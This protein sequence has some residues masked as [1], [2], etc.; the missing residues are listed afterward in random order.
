M[1]CPTPISDDLLPQVFGY[2]LGELLYLG[3][4]TAVYRAL[5]A[6][7]S[8][9]VV[10]KVLRREY[11]SFNELV[12]FC[13]QYTITKNLAI[14]GIAKP[15]SLESVGRCYA[16]IMEDN[17]EIS[18]EKY[19]QQSG[20]EISEVLTIGLQITDILHGLCQHQ[21]VHKDIKPANILI[22]PE[23]KQVKL[24]DFSIA[25]LLPK[26]TQTLLNP[27][28][29]EGTLAYLA[30]E[31]TGRMNRAID[32]R[33]DF[34]AFGVT[35]YQLLTGRL[36]F[37]SD[38]PLELVHCHIAQ[39][40]IPVH[41]V[42]PDIPV[43]VAKIVAKLMAKN[44]EDRYQSAL[45]LKHDLK[46]CLEQWNQTGT[47]PEFSLGQRDISDR[48]TIPEKLY[49]R[50]AEVETLL[51]AFERVSQGATELMLV[52]GFSGIG[53]TA[54]VNEVH[55]PITRQ[56]GYFIKGKFDQFNRNIP[57]SAF[58]QALRDLM[59]QLLSESDRQLQT[60]KT[61]ILNALGDNG[62]VMIEVIPELERIIGAQPPAPEL[63]GTAAQNRFNLLFQRFIQVFTTPEH[64]LVMFLDDLQWADSASL[65]LMQVL[66]TE[67]SLGYLLLIGA[68]R[69][70]EVFAAHPL[71]LTLDTIQKA[72]EMVNT[73]ALQPL[74]QNSLNQLITD[75]LH[76]AEPLAEPL[77]ELV[78]QKTQGNPFFTTQFLK[79]LHQ[80]KLINFDA[81]AGHWQCDIAQVRD[82]ALTDDVVEFMALQLQKLPEATQEILK[83]AACIG[84]QFDLETLAIVGEQ[85]KTAVA[86]TLWQ[87]LH[88]GLIIPVTQVY[89][90][91]QS[92]DLE[93][94][95]QQNSQTPVNPGY[96]F[97][98]DRIQQAAYS[99][100]AT[101]QKQNIH[102]KMGQTLLGE[103]SPQEREERL[104]AIVNHLNLGS[105]II[106]SPQER[107]TL[108]NLNLAAGRKAKTATAYQAAIAYFE[109]GIQLLPQDS[110][111][112][113]YDL[114]LALHEE[115][116]ESSYL[117]TQYREMERWAMIALKHARTQI[118]T[119]RVQKTRILSSTSEGKLLEGIQL[120]LQVLR[121]LGFEFPEHPTQTEIG[122]AFSVTRSLWNE[123]SLNRLLDLPPMQNPQILA[124][125]EI[126]SILVSPAYKAAPSIM[127]LLIFKQ[128]ELSIQ[129]GNCPVSVFS[130]AD[131]GLI[132]CGIIGDIENG[133]EFGALALK[134]L[135]QLQIPSLQCRSFYI[136]NQYIKHWKSSL[137]ES[138]PKLQETYQRGLET[139]DLDIACL[140]AVDYCY[141]TYLAGQELANLLKTTDTY[142]QAIQQQQQIAPLHFQ[143]I[144]QQM[145]LN[146]L[147][148]AEVPYILTGTIFSQERLLDLQTTNQRGALFRWHLNQTI[149]YY[150]FEQQTRAAQ[151]SAT[152]AQYLD[153]VVATFAIPVYFLFDALIQ[154]A[155]YT[156]AEPEVRPS[157]LQRIQQHQDQLRNWATFAPMNHQHRWELVAAEHYQILGNK[158][159]AIEYYDRAIASAKENGF[160][161]DEA[162]ANELAAKFYLNWGKD[163]VAAGYLQEA[164]YCYA[165]WGAQAKVADL[166]IRYPHLL[167]PIL[168]PPDPSTHRLN[169]L[170]TIAPVNVTVHSHYR[171][172]SSSSINQTLDFTAILRASQAL[173]SSIQLEELLNH[174]TQIILQNSG[175]DRCALILPNPSEEWQVRAIATA[176]HTHLCTEELTNHPLLPIK[177]IQYVKNTQALVVIDNLETDLPVIGDYLRQHQP[178]SVLCLPMLNQGHFTG[179]LL[180]EN[181]ATSGTFTQERVSVLN[182]LCTQAAISLENARLYTLEQQ[183]SDQLKASELRLKAIFEQATDA[184]LLL[185]QDGFIDCNQAALDLF[186][187]T[188]KSQLLN[189]YPSAISPEF[190]P[191]GISSQ[192][193][194]ALILAKS[195]EIGHLRFEWLHQRPNGQHFF[196]EVTLTAIPYDNDT[197]L[198][199]L[200]RDIS[201]RKKLER[202]QQQFID[203]LDATPDFVGL[204]SAQG[205]ILWHNKSFCEFRPDLFNPSNPKHISEC[206]P[207]WTNQII[208]EQGLPIAIQQGSW[209]GEVVLL[210]THNQEVPVSQVIIAHKSESGEVQNFSTI[211]RD[212]SDRKAAEAASK[213]FQEKL[214]FLIQ[215]TPIG[216]IEWNTE[217]Q[218]MSWNPSAE[219]IFG[220]TAEEMLG[221]HANQIVP[222]CD[223]PHV[224]LVM[225]ALLEQEGGFFSLNQNIRKDQTLITCEWINTPLRDTQDNAIGIFSMIQDVSD[226]IAAEA[227]IRQK[228]QAL[229][230]TLQE[231]QNTQLQMVQSEKMASLGNLV[232]GI[233]HEINN[234]IGFL[235]GSITNGK[236]YL[237]DLLEHLNL[238]QTHYPN[239]ATEIQD[240]A[241]NIDLEFLRQDFLKLIN[242]MHGATDRIKSI[243]TSLRTFSR[244]DLEH[245]V[246]ANL[247]EGID[248]TILILKY[249]LKANEHRPAIEVL[250]N[251]GDIPEIQCFPGQINQVFMNIIANAID[252]FDE[253]A[254]KTTYSDLQL[255]PQQITIQT[256]LEGQNTV[257]IRIQDN[258][259]GMNEDVKARIFDHL[260]TTKGVGQGTGL[261][262]AIARQIVEE[263]HGGLLAVESQVGQGSTF[264]IQLPIV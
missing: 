37:N 260:F 230:Q 81:A 201:D 130:Y 181:Q 75:T 199:C 193:K 197:I 76:C 180:L 252:M 3:T 183:K 119:T 79:T 50:E 207:Q 254:Q 23:S 156:S 12:Q 71:M 163:K 217:F 187:Y 175:A 149:L 249:R 231:L 132:L 72:G 57:L 48:F 41:Q 203:I 227:T 190:Q 244:A 191:D 213:A 65:N 228:S 97:L 223:R 178:K 258:G 264:V 6:E 215:K 90:F 133:Y 111:Q 144:S 123:R 10:I 246:S 20:L 247:H 45:G 222:E 171:K 22:H 99:L 103:A 5:K 60:W 105:T 96:R 137:S 100:I 88:E 186:Q 211:M 33:T 174:L 89:R 106:T 250:Q 253:M 25:S 125:M 185:N 257:E 116:T 118:D 40:P 225:Q 235:N 74:S 109:Q 162:L 214:T 172:S 255:N 242:S 200:V 238:Y 243:S 51:N 139:G 166:E 55:K 63:S 11:P 113:H 240:H 134:L 26:E 188:E 84:A 108:A 151:N 4:R 210:D 224:A 2:T 263:K 56:N 101:D 182:L 9:P 196:A 165:R 167:H 54:I 35:L 7:G 212:I 82:A 27:N 1:L 104:F 114:S 234:P 159:E 198:H 16:L 226:R 229:E 19:I 73:I 38:D 58:V 140:S 262:L 136:V 64:P 152:T 87:A 18:L 21:I 53:K 205:Q 69:D 117:N 68:Y 80:D 85:S 248:S 209:S 161:Q 158:T 126:L 102:L 129:F 24:I 176:E 150:L 256:K 30:P 218:V 202:E 164:Y 14:P 141:G 155:Q 154:C 62:Q 120:G 219:K 36:P 92:I 34:Y 245:K 169:P 8:E 95:D 204:A 146:L 195:L 170:M 49:G 157:I 46:H 28:S 43:M 241:E 31:Q 13:N 192:E 77:T 145:L 184:I 42:N 142:R 91:F 236:D 251:Y 94:F 206:H 122:Q 15:L 78:M 59:G 110:W 32:Y 39:Q 143:E 44:A 47:I 232:A 147:G 83:L 239:P 52:A 237:K 115:I 261:G 121:E 160:I 220:Y 107:E 216:I 128:V 124:A 233:A 127:P 194:E 135:E 67:A 189:I 221:Q 17:G 173:S 168:E 153:G 179:I 112:T 66:M 61:Q 29:L 148:K 93:Q 70:N 131:Y 138:L 86:A 98:H 259:K 177:L 208:R